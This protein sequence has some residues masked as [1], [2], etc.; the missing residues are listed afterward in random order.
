M[1]VAVGVAVGVAV[2]VAVGATVAVAVAVGVGVGVAQA[3]G[4]G[5]LSINPETVPLKT[6]EFVDPV[7]VLTTTTKFVCAGTVN[8]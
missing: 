7:V 6:D 5:V 4:P 8:E 1:A 2:A 3:P